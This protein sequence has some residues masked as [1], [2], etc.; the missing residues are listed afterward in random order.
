[1]ARGNVLLMEWFSFQIYQ[2]QRLGTSLADNHDCFE[3]ELSGF[4]E[5]FDNSGT[6]E[7]GAAKSSQS[8]FL[9]K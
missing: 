9:K 1:M 2:Q 6:K 5:L 8:S 4:R 7:N 3:L